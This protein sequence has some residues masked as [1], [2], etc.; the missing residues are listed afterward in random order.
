[1][2]RF[3]YLVYIVIAV[4]AIG[5][6]F[7]FFSKNGGGIAEQKLTRD[8]AAKMIIAY[9]KAHAET[10]NIT[11]NVSFDNVGCPSAQNKYYPPISAEGLKTKGY[12]KD[13]GT[14]LFQTSFTEKAKPYVVNDTT[15]IIAKVKDVK[16]T[17]LVDEG[18]N[19]TAAKVTYIYE[20][21]P[22]GEACSYPTEQENSVYFQLYDDGWRIMTL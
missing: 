14:L 6:A 20:L 16:V 8:K 15:A 22:F 17:G 10:T 13:A 5:G 4:A 19:Q 18:N 2:K 11:A 7:F 1:M 3:K 9:V 12:V 21:T